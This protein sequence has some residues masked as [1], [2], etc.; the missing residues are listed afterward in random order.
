MSVDGT[1]VGG[2]TSDASGHVCVTGLA[3]GTTYTVTE[4]AAPAGYSLDGPKSVTV[5]QGAD[6]C[7]SASTPATVSF[8]DSPL[9][10]ISCSF[11]SDAGVTAATIQCTGETANTSFTTHD[12]TGL[13][14]G[15]YTCTFVITSN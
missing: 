12:L 8:V 14:P 1:V 4:T 9:S 15:S 11:D 6:D 5:T 10:S 13:V 7:S 2:G 3:I